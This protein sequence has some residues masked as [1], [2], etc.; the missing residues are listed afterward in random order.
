MHLLGG[1]ERESLFQVEAHLVT[2]DGNGAGAGPVGFSAAVFQ[3][4][5]KQIK[6]LTHGFLVMSGEA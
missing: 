3:D 4:M 6:V 1:E 5:F 2:E